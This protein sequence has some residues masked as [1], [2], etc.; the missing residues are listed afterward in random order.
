MDNQGTKRIQGIV[1]AF[2]YYARAV[3]NKLIVGLSSIVSYQAAATEPT[4]KA[5]NQIIDYCDTYPADGTLYC[6]SDMVLCAHS[7]ACF[8][9]EIK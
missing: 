6:S 2:L 1:G 8:H 9:N 3:D 5:I 4:N 7:D